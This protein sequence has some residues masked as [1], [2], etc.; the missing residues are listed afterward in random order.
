VVNAPP[1]CYRNADL[2]ERQFG[3]LARRYAAALSSASQRAIPR[4][5]SSGW[6]SCT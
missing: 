6:S 2:A 4:P 1:A 3:D 5:I